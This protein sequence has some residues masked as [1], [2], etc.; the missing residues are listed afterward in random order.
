MPKILP[1]FKPFV[2][3]LRLNNK[4]QAMKNIFRLVALLI[5]VW[6]SHQ[7]T[8]AQFGLED[9]GMPKSDFP[10]PPNSETAT[11]IV[12]VNLDYM[13]LNVG[14][15]LVHTDE[16]TGIKL[17]ANRQVQTRNYTLR[18]FDPETKKDVEIAVER[19]RENPQCVFVVIGGDWINVLCSQNYRYV[20]EHV[21]KAP[22]T[23]PI[24]TPS[25]KATG[26]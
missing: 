17:I 22:N 4:N 20:K 8:F 14:D 5:L 1:F 23:L 24:P 18:A 15:N 16:A 9:F 7:N 21:N 13:M 6:G 19:S 2:C 3:F 25:E 11:A 26:K 12:N 10:T